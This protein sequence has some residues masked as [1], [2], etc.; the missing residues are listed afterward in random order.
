MQTVS[1][2]SSILR[3]SMT[4]MFPLDKFYWKLTKVKIVGFDRKL[5]GLPVPRQ[6]SVLIFIMLLLVINI[7]IISPTGAACKR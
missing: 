1:G 6:L 3:H 7:I 5:F 2:L 4:K